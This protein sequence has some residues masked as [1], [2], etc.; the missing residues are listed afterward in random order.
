MHDS[1]LCCCC[2]LVLLRSSVE[3]D[4]LAFSLRVSEKHDGKDAAEQGSA[5]CRGEKGCCLR[6]EGEGASQALAFCFLSRSPGEQLLEVDSGSC[7]AENKA[8]RL[9]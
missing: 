4:A 1:Y 7:E 6:A 3:A 8:G 9:S 2:C 5:E